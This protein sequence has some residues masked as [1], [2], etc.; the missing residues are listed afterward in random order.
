MAEDITNVTVVLT[1]QPPADANGVII[2]YT[3]E[4][5]VQ[6]TSNRVG[7]QVLSADTREYDNFTLEPFTNYTASVFANTS[8]GAGAP[9]TVDFTTEIG[10]KK[11]IQMLIMTC[12]QAGALVWV[13]VQK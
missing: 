7:F 12:S 13:L 6:D 4:V 8:F 1:W 11:S 10:S 2:Y 9:A 3:I 5:F